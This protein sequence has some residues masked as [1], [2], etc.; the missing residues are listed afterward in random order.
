MKLT[1]RPNIDS[2]KSIV[3]ATVILNQAQITILGNQLFYS[4]NK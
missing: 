2:L 3:F 1:Y 4:G